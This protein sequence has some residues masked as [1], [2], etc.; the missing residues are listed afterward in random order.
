MCYVHMGTLIDIVDQF[1][2][3]A[4]VGPTWATATN[5][6][7]LDWAARRETAARRSRKKSAAPTTT[8]RFRHSGASPGTNLC[9]DRMSTGWTTP[10]TPR[11]TKLNRRNVDIV[12]PLSICTVVSLPSS[13][14]AT[15]I[16]T[17]CMYVLYNC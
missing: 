14:S 13:F 7:R 12:Y 9:C 8:V 4:R 11:R 10:V 1:G 15:P 2:L 3:S 5:Y 17:P 6:V 16:C